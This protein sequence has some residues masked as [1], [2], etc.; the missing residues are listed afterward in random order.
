MKQNRRI[1]VIIPCLNE[2][3]AI[4]KVF[5]QWGQP[6]S[7][8]VYLQ[9]AYRLARNLNKA[10]NIKATLKLLSD[11]YEQ[12]ESMKAL[13]YYKAYIQYRDSAQGEETKLRLAQLTQKNELASSKQK[14]LKLIHMRSSV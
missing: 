12:K 11:C 9:E 14:I 3:Q 5:L 10:A 1:E 6:D 2:E 13:Y 8:E 7:A 4:G